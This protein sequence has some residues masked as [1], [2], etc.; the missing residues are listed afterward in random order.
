KARDLHSR[1]LIYSPYSQPG[2]YL[3][4]DMSMSYEE[5]LGKFKSK[6]RQT[7]ARKLRYLERESAGNLE[8][9]RVSN[10]EGVGSF[11]RAAHAIAKVTWQ[12]HLVDLDVDQPA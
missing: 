5:Y 12:H 11:L 4:I 9:L 7:F 10:V 6:T 1:W 3:F 8:L 2:K